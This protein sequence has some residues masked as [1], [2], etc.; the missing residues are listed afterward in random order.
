MPEKDFIVE[1]QVKERKFL[2]WNLILG[3]WWHSSC[4]RSTIFTKL[5]SVTVFIVATHTPT[6]IGWI[7]GP[8]YVWELNLGMHKWAYMHAAEVRAVTD[9]SRTHKHQFL[10]RDASGISLGGNLK[11]NENVRIWIHTGLNL[12]LSFTKSVSVF[13]LVVDQIARKLSVIDILYYFMRYSLLF[14]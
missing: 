10:P 12:S 4:Q 2:D 1:F 14:W 11:C 7:A 8:M 9:C 5:R 3:Y 13:F 6:S